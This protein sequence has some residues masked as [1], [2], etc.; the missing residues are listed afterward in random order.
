ML[1]AKAG[2]AECGAGSFF[3]PGGRGHAGE[4]DDPLGDAG[5]DKIQTNFVRAVFVLAG[6]LDGRARFQTLSAVGVLRE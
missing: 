1:R 6:G 5:A 3:D 2:H 4:I